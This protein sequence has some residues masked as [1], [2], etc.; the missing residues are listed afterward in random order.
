MCFSAIFTSFPRK[1]LSAEKF[2][3]IFS[4]LKVRIIFGKYF[5]Y[6][7]HLKYIWEVDIIF[8]NFVL[9]LKFGIIFEK[10]IICAIE[11]ILYL[12]I[13]YYSIM[14]YF[15]LY[16]GISHYICE[17]VIIFGNF[18]LYLDILL[19]YLGISH[20]ICMFAIIFFNFAFNIRNW[21]YIFGLHNKYI[22][23][24]DYCPSWRAIGSK[25][26][27]IMWSETHLKTDLS[28]T[29]SANPTELT[30]VLT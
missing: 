2:R 13:S 24:I 29:S 11:L 16:L 5:K 12:E 17:F 6:I 14:F 18:A 7:C 9:Y 15:A 28:N 19:L 27:T 26:F 10:L 3:I 22:R 4:R 23:L 21:S 25:Q 30:H 8:G 20:Y 1:K